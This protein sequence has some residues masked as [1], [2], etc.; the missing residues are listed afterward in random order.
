LE[1]PFERVVQHL[2]NGDFRAAEV[3][4]L[5]PSPYYRARLS[6]ADRLLFR[7][8]HYKGRKHIL[9]LEVIRNHAYDRSRFLNGAVVDEGKLAPLCSPEETGPADTVALAYVNPQSKHFNVLDKIISFDDVQ[10]EIFGLRLP[11]IL[12]GAAGS[13]KTVLTLEKLKQLAG[14]V[15]YVTH[16]PFLAENSATL[17]YSNNYENELQ[18]VDFLSF[19]EY[20]ETWGVPA[21]R[22]LV[23]YDFDRW[24]GRH[25]HSAHLRDSHKVF[26]EFNGVI[27]GCRVDVPCLSKE[28]YLGLG[29]RRS[30]FLSGE[31]GEVYDLFVR[32]QEWIK[33][34]GFYDLNMAAYAALPRVVAKYDFVVVDE[35]Q[36]LTNVQLCLALKSLRTAGDFVLCGDSNQIV[37]P[38]FFSWANVKTLFYEKNVAG[39]GDLM[40]VLNTNYRNSPQVTEM[41]NRLLLIKNARFGSVDRES[42]YL[43]RCNSENV[44]AV[45]FLPDDEKIK[46]ELNEKTRRSARY[47]VMVMR[48]EDKATAQRFF[49]TPLLFSIQEAKGLEYENIILFNFV[50]GNAEEFD[51]IT[52]GV[53]EGDLAGEIKYARPKDK[54]DKAL[55]AF[56]F[57]INALYVAMTRAVQN[58]YIIESRPSHRL[59]RLLGLVGARDGLKLAEQKSSVQEWQEEARKLELQGKQEQADAIRQSVLSIQPVPWKVLTPRTLADLEKEA[60]DPARFNKQAKQLVYEYA[61]MHSAI[62]LL[63]R[64]V[65]HKFNRAKN[66]GQDNANVLRKYHQDY[67]ERSLA[68]LNRKIAAYGVDFRNPMNQTPLMIA[69]QL[70]MAE[71]VSSLLKHGANPDLTDNWGRTPVQI[72]LR[73]AALSSEYARRSVGNVY[74]LLAPRSIKTKVEGRLVKIDKH[75]MEY[76]LVNF[77]LSVAD[78][79]LRFKIEYAIPAFQTRDFIGALIP[80]PAHVIPERRKNR[81]YISGVLARN[82]VQRFEPGNKKLFLRIRHG[83]Y[84]LNPCME[85]EVNG[86]WVNVYDLIQIG[87][88]EK[89]T[90]N[91]LLMQFIEYIRQCQQTNNFTLA[92]QHEATAGDPAEESPEPAAPA[93]GLSGCSPAIPS[94]LPAPAN[95]DDPQ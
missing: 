38:N 51:E 68:E 21:G 25:V 53:A 55:E 61:L 85:L 27:T 43:V 74:A 24:F 33:A 8:G 48:S 86:A 44:G 17:Y 95:P 50:S 83:Y 58:L 64:L 88:L 77:M 20:L 91:P 28:D 52:D 14:D 5:A 69:G 90:H 23:Y 57:Y 16:S 4:K 94:P 65:E 31:R 81:A 49:Q 30:I 29:V 73:E 36:D 34:D 6:D 93:E 78:R 47:A 79:I 75:Q 56:K 32:Y 41:A 46:R 37:H 70:G 35:V 82:E 18:N 62:H 7:I 19:T 9:L 71:L 13:G 10:N 15:L 59:L 92:S 40:R 2:R 87:E 63:D 12:I 60:F 67:G 45:E 3:K 42:N 26:E 39:Q 1:K 54:T 89:E 11:F 72:A 76:F 66:P 22:A 80:F 84:I